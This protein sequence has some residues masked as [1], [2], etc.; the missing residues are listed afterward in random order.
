MRHSLDSSFHDGTPLSP[1]VT[2]LVPVASEKGGAADSIVPEGMLTDPTQNNL[3]NRPVVQT[4]PLPDGVSIL[5]QYVSFDTC[6][7]SVVVR[8]RTG[9]CGVF[10][11]LVS[12]VLQ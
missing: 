2:S 10:P 1:S 11:P 4:A 3:F 8:R 9:A 5:A 12:R 6:M 7:A